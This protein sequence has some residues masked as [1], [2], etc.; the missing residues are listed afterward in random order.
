[1]RRSEPRA[2][3][4]EHGGPRSISSIRRPIRSQL[5]GAVPRRSGR[6]VDQ[7]NTDLQLALSALGTADVIWR[8]N[9]AVIDAPDRRVPVDVRLRRAGAKRV[10]FASSAALIEGF[11]RCTAVD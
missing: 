4:V 1:M 5:V 10:R 8:L 6:T 2:L 7:A 3:L 9:I 11:D